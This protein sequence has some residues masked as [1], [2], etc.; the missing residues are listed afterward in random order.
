MDYKNGKVV[1]N[2]SRYYP[3]GNETCSTYNSS[4]Y[5][6]SMSRISSPSGRNEVTKSL[7]KSNMFNGLSLNNIFTD[8]NNGTKIGVASGNTQFTFIN[9]Q[10]F[11][12]TT[13]LKTFLQNNAGVLYVDHVL[14][15]PIE[16]SVTLPNILLNKGS[17]IVD[18]NTTIKPSNMYVE[19]K[20]GTSR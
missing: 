6:W 1:R 5:G 12:S 8:R 13:D 9:K 17:N 4:L 20:G 11:T 15:T 14:A 19:Y 18:V 3:T 7:T 16:E 10:N 2:I